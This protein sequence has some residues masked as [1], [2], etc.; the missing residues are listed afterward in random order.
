MSTRCVSHDP[1]CRRCALAAAGLV[2]L[3]LSGAASA[4]GPGDRAG[5]AGLAPPA[6]LV[7]TAEVKRTPVEDTTEFVA[8][9]QSLSSRSIKPEV[10]GEVV[11]VLVRSGD[12]VGAGEPLF[13]IDPARQQASVSSQDAART[14]QV[15]AVTFARQQ[16]ERAKILEK[17]GAA[18]QQ[19]LD[20]AQAAYD[21][22]TSQL[23]ALDARLQQ[24]RVTLGY[25]LVRAPD[26]GSVGDIPV[27]VGTHVTTDTVLTT[28]DRNQDLEV[29][30][31]VPLERSADLK[32]GLPILIDGDGGRSA[33][34]S[35]YFISPRVDDQTQAVLVKGRVPAEAGLRTSQFVRAR[36]VWNTTDRLTVP[37]LSVVRINGQPFVFVAETRGGGL[38][39][40]ERRVTLGPI[41]GNDQVVLDGLS[42]GERIVVSGVQKLGNGSIIRTS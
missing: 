29:D 26:T 41:V 9:I 21:E 18:T 15:A 20:Q 40:A 5:A 30:V 8:T 27:R 16:L 11:K 3:L 23:T 31:R 6:T 42:G 35:I 22:A 25:Y 19:D 17:A 39:A 10:T 12:R 36:I 13:Q 38:V 1:G 37:V 33:R 14:A 34:S 4:C 32:I 7:Q 28:V 24:E 2:L